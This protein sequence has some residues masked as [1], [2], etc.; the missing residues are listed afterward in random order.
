M[1]SQPYVGAHLAED[2]SI[3]QGAK[4][5]KSLLPKRYATPWR[6]SSNEKG[7][8]WVGWLRVIQGKMYVHVCT[9]KY[10][11]N[12][13]KYTAKILISNYST[14]VYIHSVY[15]IHLLQEALV[16]CLQHGGRYHL[17][18]RLVQ[19]VVLFYDALWEKCIRFMPPAVHV[20]F[21]LDLCT[22]DVLR[23]ETDI[24]HQILLESTGDLGP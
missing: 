5:R 17:R 12:I 15:Q 2:V 11:T 14:H 18:S 19:S 7:E 20:S 22:P 9:F 4:N 8:S 1:K 13:K 23:K 3:C 6:T 10:S 24:C 16:L 21:G